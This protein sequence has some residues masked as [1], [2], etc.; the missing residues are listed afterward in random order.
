VGGGG[1]GGAGARA[2]V[3]DRLFCCPEMKKKGGGGEKGR[4]FRVTFGFRVFLASSPSLTSAREGG[5]RKK[6]RKGGKK[7]E[8]M[9]ETNPFARRSLSR[10]SLP[11]QVEGER[12]KRGEREER[13]EK[14][15]KNFHG[16]IRPATVAVTSLF[17]SLSRVGPSGVKRKKGR[18]RRGK[19]GTATAGW[20]RGR[21]LSSL[22]FIYSAS[23]RKKGEEGERRKRG[24][25]QGPLVLGTSPP[26]PVNRL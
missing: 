25:S 10:S 22:T 6:R 4:P 19:G 23:L 26:L 21:T 1:G 15:G 8:R 3:L 17:D 20:R 5:K 11:R 7:R 13:E 18:K 2:S 14:E 24:S 9:R 16:I 12:K